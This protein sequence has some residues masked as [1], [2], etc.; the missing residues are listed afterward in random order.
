MT[1]I[2]NR[3][4]DQA[5]PNSAKPR[6]NHYLP[7]KE[8]SAQR[9]NGIQHLDS[10]LLASSQHVYQRH[11]TNTETRSIEQEMTSDKTETSRISQIRT[12]AVPWIQLSTL[13]EV[14]RPW[15]DHHRDVYIY[16]HCQAD[17]SVHHLPRDSRHMWLVWNLC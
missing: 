13:P 8:G 10:I 4:K 16:Q 12:S 2:Y 15:T 11:T 3:G 7:K 9:C 14:P 17:K 5:M 1:T 6:I